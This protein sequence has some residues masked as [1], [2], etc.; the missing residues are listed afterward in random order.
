MQK[1]SVIMK[2]QLGRRCNVLNWKFGI[3]DIGPHFQ[4]CRCVETFF[5]L[6]VSVFSYFS[7]ASVALVSG[8]C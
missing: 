8:H 1:K 7:D 6:S 5:N 3:F 4:C 2:A